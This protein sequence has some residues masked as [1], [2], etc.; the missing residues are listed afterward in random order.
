[1]V[2]Q[3]LD[4]RRS[5]WISQGGRPTLAAEVAVLILKLWDIQFCWETKMLEEGAKNTSNFGSGKVAARRKGEMH[6]WLNAKQGTF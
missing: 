4:H 5:V 2:K 6:C 3:C 1:M